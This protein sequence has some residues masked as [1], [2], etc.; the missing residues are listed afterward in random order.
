M[1][2]NEND[3]PQRETTIE[4]RL[5]NMQDAIDANRSA[6]EIRFA[7]IESQLGRQH[8]QQQQQ[9]QQ[10][11]MVIPRPN[12]NPTKDN[13][14]TLLFEH[15][16]DEEE[17]DVVDML[18]IVSTS[19]S[20][21]VDALLGTG[22][23]QFTTWTS[24][25]ATQIYRILNTCREECISRDPRLSFMDSATGLWTYDIFA[26]QYWIQRSYYRR[27]SSKK[28]PMLARYNYKQQPPQQ[29]PQPQQQQELQQLQIEQIEQL[30]LQIEQQ[31]LQEQQAFTPPPAVPSTPPPAKAAVGDVALA[32][33]AVGD[34][35]PAEAAVGDV[36]P[37]TTAAATDVALAAAAIL[38][39]SSLR[40][41]RRGR[42]GC[43]RGRGARGRGDRGR[44]G[45][46]RG[47]R[48]SG[49]GGSN[50][51]LEAVQEGRVQKRRPGRPPGNQNKT[52]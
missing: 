31:R 50:D 47:G 27:R 23:L 16:P 1:S 35:A 46:G 8:P 9:Q 2:E 19:C 39:G 24:L 5:Q 25:D 21:T 51:E 42:G 10:Q 43:G 22:D 45:R 28:R 11:L 44:G 49:T 52:K 14:E 4:Q 20:N 30:R 37:A 18:D 15:F 12:Q 40:G 7:F 38:E 33:A 36:A 48:G 34:V 29:Q 32:E 6:A 3:I 13:L 26:R 41:G 17:Q